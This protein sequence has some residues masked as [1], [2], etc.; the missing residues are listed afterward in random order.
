MLT[1]KQEIF[2]IVAPHLLRQRRQSLLP[3]SGTCAYRGGSGLMCAVGVLI[4]EDKYEAQIEAQSVGRDTVKRI[5]GTIVELS[6]DN[7]S[8]LKE[9]QQIHDGTG[10]YYVPGK[11]L[12]RDTDAFSRWKDNLTE[13]AQ[14]YG[15]KTKCLKGLIS[16]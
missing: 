7:L 5:L 13:L 4:P 6:E 3:G 15:L 16:D 2:D 10:N 1:T 8:F 11:S 9:L 12:N 14:R